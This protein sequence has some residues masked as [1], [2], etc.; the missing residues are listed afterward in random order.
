VQS[1]DKFQL[2]VKY[3]GI[4]SLKGEGGAVHKEPTRR[5]RPPYLEALTPIPQ[6]DCT[7]EEIKEAIGDQVLMDG[8]VPQPFQLIVQ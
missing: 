6:G 1:Q 3:K 4:I 2:D 5:G 8:L 7:L